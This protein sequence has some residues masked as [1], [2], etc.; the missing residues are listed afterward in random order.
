LFVGFVGAALDYKAAERLP[1]ELA[2]QR[3][4]GADERLREELTTSEY[5]DGVGQRLQEPV[6]RG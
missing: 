4:N 6:H 5:A 2:E 3:A 1:M